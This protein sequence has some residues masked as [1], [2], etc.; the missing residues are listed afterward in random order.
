[1]EIRVPSPPAAAGSVGKLP[2]ERIPDRIEHDESRNNGADRRRRQPEQLVVEKQEQ[3]EQLGLRAE[4]DGAEAVGQ[5]GE[6][7]A[8]RPSICL[9][10]EGVWAHAARSFH[11]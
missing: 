10:L 5:P 8:F 1:M 3:T 6:E 11:S 9:S 2:D 4:R 7:I